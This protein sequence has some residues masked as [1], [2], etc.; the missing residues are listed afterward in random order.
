MVGVRRLQ[1]PHLDHRRTALDHAQ[2]H[3]RGIAEI[4]HP[5]RD[6]R[7]AIIDPQDHG[8]LIA[9]IGYPHIARQRQRR[10]RCRKR[11]HV[12]CLAIG[13]SPTVKIFAVPGGHTDGRISGVL[14]GMFA[15]GFHGALADRV[16]VDLAGCGDPR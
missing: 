14:H 4:D 2:A 6:E 15:C 1:R 10:M 7:P 11:V 9:E 5:V 16:L 13:G 12:E 3:G 8:A